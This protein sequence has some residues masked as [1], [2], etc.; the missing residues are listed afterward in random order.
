M[1]EPET[2]KDGYKSNLIT[3]ASPPSSKANRMD[4]CVGVER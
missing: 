2:E 3:L 1:A 4:K